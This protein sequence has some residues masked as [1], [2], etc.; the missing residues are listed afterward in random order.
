MTKDKN[1]KCNLCALKVRFDQDKMAK[2][3]EV[4]NFF[5]T[6]RALQHKD[7][8]EK[9][10][11]RRIFASIGTDGSGDKSEMC[12]V[13][14][15]FFLKDNRDKKCPEFILNMDLTI[16]DALSLN[17]SKKN[18]KL[19]FDIKHLTWILVVLTL[20]LLWLGIMQW[21]QNTIIPEL[22]PNKITEHTQQSK[23]NAQMDQVQKLLNPIKSIPQIESPQ[24]G[25]DKTHKPISEKPSNQANSADAKSRAAD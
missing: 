21:T 18:V 2:E 16:A 7:I 12:A 9:G 10:Y 11:N 22:E 19:A 24:K 13:N 25:M 3:L 6:L 1:D 5:T 8:I 4:E 23:K 15:K 14:S 20:A 17:L